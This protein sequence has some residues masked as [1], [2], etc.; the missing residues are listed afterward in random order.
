M[1]NQ[2]M[3]ITFITFWWLKAACMHFPAADSVIINSRGMVGHHLMNPPSTQVHADSLGLYVVKLAPS[4]L[5]SVESG[6]EV[7]ALA[8]HPVCLCIRDQCWRLCVLLHNAIRGSVVLSETSVWGPVSHDSMLTDIHPHTDSWLLCRLVCHQQHHTPVSLSC[9]F[10]PSSCFVRFIFCCS[11]PKIFTAFFFF[12]IASCMHCTKYSFGICFILP[13]MFGFVWMFLF[14]FVLFLR[15]FVRVLISGLNL[16]Y[17]MIFILW[18][19]FF[20]FCTWLI[21]LSPLWLEQW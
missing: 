2:R 16:R 10:V 4:L 7:R 5:V 12:Y 19:I 15:Y 17:S 11:K 14:C 18:Y 1:T 13:K 8:R 21:V 3:Y 9:F 20:S 6:D